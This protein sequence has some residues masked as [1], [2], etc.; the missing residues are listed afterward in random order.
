MSDAPTPVSALAMQG[1]EV[2]HYSAAIDSG[3]L[4]QHCFLM[5]KGGR[6]KVL[7]VRDKMMGEGFVAEER[8]V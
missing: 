8:D 1:W 7:M 4:F 6:Y 3:G 2:A 5:R